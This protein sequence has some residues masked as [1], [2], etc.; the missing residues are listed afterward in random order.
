NDPLDF[1]ARYELALT[2]PED[3]AVPLEELH[4]LMRGEAQTYLDLALDYAMAGMDEEA[5]GLLEPLAA[6]S[7]LYHPMVAYTL[8]FLYRR[9][10]ETEEAAGWQ[11]QAQRA[12]PEY[13]FPWRLEEQ[14]ILEDALRANP[15][16]ARASYYLG[17]LLYDKKR[18]TP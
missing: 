6:R 18:Y 4:R 17:N 3:L 1:W 9:A 12:A 13:C 10:G 16:D 8:S 14:L 5:I 11:R 2:V 15:D 7:V